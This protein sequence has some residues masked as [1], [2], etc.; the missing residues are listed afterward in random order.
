[1]AILGPS[2][3]TEVFY[4]STWSLLLVRVP[5]DPIDGSLCPDMASHGPTEGPCGVTGPF[6]L[7]R[8]PLWPET[9]C[10]LAI[11]GDLLFQ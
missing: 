11:Q 1:M 2:N 8:G 4:G 10:L 7:N 6:D 5:C 3:M 9:R